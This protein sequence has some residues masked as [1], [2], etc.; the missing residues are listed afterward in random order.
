[1]AARHAELFRAAEARS[2][3]SFIRGGSTNVALRPTGG[4]AMNSADVAHMVGNVWEWTSDCM[5]N[6]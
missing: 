1:M 4:F 3:T 2:G 6:S 5:I